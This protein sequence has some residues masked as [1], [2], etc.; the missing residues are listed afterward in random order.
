[1]TD[2]QF[3]FEICGMPEFDLG[4][5]YGVVISKPYIPHFPNDMSKWNGF[6]LVAQA[7]NLSDTY[8]PYREALEQCDN[9]EYLYDRLNLSS[10]HFPSELCDNGHGVYRDVAIAPWQKGVIP[11]AIAAASYILGYPSPSDPLR[12]I[13]GSAVM[14]AIPWSR[15]AYN[16]NNDALIDAPPRTA[17]VRKSEDFWRKLLPALLDSKGSLVVCTFGKKAHEVLSTAVGQVENS[18]LRLLSFPPPFNRPL[19]LNANGF[20]DEAQQILPEIRLELDRLMHLLT[21]RYGF[22]CDERLLAYHL[23]AV[24]VGR[25]RRL[26]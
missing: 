15:V 17:I 22:Q 18:R 11:F 2:R 6:L 24:V 1:M 9:T 12:A 19:N 4:Q 5:Q 21:I 23:A 26:P 7:Q 25:L 14:N 16:N 10:R 20:R 3:L 8:R 13:E